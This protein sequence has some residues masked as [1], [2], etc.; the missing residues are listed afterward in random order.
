MIPAQNLSPRR[1]NPRL[2]R[3]H[4]AVRRP[5]IAFQKMGRGLCTVLI[6]ILAAASGALGAETAR[7][8]S[9]VKRIYIMHFSHTDIGFTDMPGVC[10]ELQRRYLDIALDAV[11]ATLPNASGPKNLSQNHD[12]SAPRP[13]NSG[14]AHGSGIGPKMYWTC[15][16]LVTVDD[17]WQ[18]ASSARREE[19]L[20]ALRSGQLDVAA[21]PCNQTP[22]LDAA[23]WQTML[24]WIP[25][26]L[27][28]QFQPTVALQNDVN[29]FPR[30]GAM[31]L[32]DRNVK[33]L[34][35]GI[36]GDS[37]GPP[38]SGPRRSGGRCPTGGGCSSG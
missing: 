26:D 8:E 13:E 12:K 22:F 34:C 25:E 16:S 6:L 20:K 36:N 15:E 2:R 33:Y 14:A 19:F 17:W 35:M 7:R 3:H 37:G 32:L 27:W 11:L 30:A 9:S 1:G 5:G 31:A 23:Q 28:R 18:A 38:S 24:H 21:L 4:G 10:R 29:G